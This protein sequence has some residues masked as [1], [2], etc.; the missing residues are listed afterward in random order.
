MVPR[1][2]LRVRRTSNLNSP[3]WSL[4]WEVWFSLLMPLMFVLIRLTRANRCSPSLIAPAGWGP[5]AAFAYLLS[6]VGVLTIVA[7][8]FASPAR[9]PLEARPVQWVGKRSFSL[10]LVHEPILVAAALLVGVSGWW[11]WV[12]IAVALVPAI[13][14]VAAL[15]YRVVEQPSIGLSRRVG[16][17]L[18]ALGARARNLGGKQ[19]GPDAFASGPRMLPDLDSNQEPAG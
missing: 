18:A 2:L 12:P 11:P 19:K 6:F 5:L 16:R 8:A 7:L 13:L 10:Y 14:L 9:R 3:L 17:L 15:F 4:T 1:D